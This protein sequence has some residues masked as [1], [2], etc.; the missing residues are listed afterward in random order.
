[1]T[2]IQSRKRILDTNEGRRTVAH[3]PRRGSVL[4]R[5]G[6]LEQIPFPCQDHGNN[7]TIDVAKNTLFLHLIVIIETKFKLQI[8]PSIGKHL[9]RYHHLMPKGSFQEV[10]AFVWL[11][12]EMHPTSGNIFQ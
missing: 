7:N 8:P 2:S 11:V 10:I 3:H 9:F 5:D 6:I 1:M 4:K 12:K